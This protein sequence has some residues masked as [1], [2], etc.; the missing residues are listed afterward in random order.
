M[1]KLQRGGITFYAAMTI[2]LV[3]IGILTYMLVMRRDTLETTTVTD[4]ISPIMSDTT[5]VTNDYDEFMT[6]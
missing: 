4:V 2:L 3:A 6:A 1:N 5:S